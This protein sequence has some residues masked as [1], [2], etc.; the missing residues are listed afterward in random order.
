MN[1]MKTFLHFHIGRG[2]RFFN[3]GNKTFKG[4]RGIGDVLC[5][6]DNGKN[7][8]FLR[9]RDEKGRFC[10]PHYTDQNGNFL[11][12]AKDVDANGEGCLDWDGQYDTDI[13]IELS[14]CDA[15]DL[16]LILESDEY[17]KLNIIKEYFNMHADVNA[18]ELNTIAD[19]EH[20]I[21]NCF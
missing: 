19:Y 10:A 16:Q 2:G 18:D 11:I 13:C 7:N 6:C 4:K 9:N 14:S 17:D 12:S 1:N 8:S 5:L 15:N 21:A 3:P 20:A